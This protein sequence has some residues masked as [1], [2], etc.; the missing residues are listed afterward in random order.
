MALAGLEP[1]PV[2]GNEATRL[3]QSGEIQPGIDAVGAAIPADLAW[4]TTV[5]PTLPA[6][7]QESILMIARDGIGEF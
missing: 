3:R 6:D 7:V 4:L 5:W 1:D 2:T